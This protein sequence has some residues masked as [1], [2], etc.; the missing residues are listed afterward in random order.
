MKVIDRK[1]KSKTMNDVKAVETMNKNP[2][3]FLEI[4]PVQ[5]ESLL[6]INCKMMHVSNRILSD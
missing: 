1:K 5:S 3:N 2:E 4:R 6:Q